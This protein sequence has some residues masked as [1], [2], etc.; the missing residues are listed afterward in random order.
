MQRV[1]LWRDETRLYTHAVAAHPRSARAWLAY[2]STQFQN[3][4]FQSATRS[5]KEAANIMGPSAEAA[6]ALQSIAAH[7][8]KQR[9]IPES[10]WQQLRNAPE[11]GGNLITL[12]GLAW[13][14]GAFEND[15]CSKAERQRVRQIIQTKSLA[16]IGWD[17][18]AEQLRATHL[19]A[20]LSSQ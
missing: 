16:P 11:L 6:I 1:D 15:L 4:D 9:A 19:K 14:A 20:L 5:L 3:D 8:L 7:C 12:N 18:A 13:M 2:A 10:L 17:A